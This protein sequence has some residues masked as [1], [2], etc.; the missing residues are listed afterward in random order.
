[1]KL[2]KAYQKLE[3]QQVQSPEALQHNYKHLQEKLKETEEQLEQA[4]ET[5][6]EKK[7]AIKL[8]Q[9]SD[10]NQEVR[11]GLLNEIVAVAKIVKYVDCTYDLC[12]KFKQP[13]VE[14]LVQL[15]SLSFL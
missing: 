7:K 8:F 2:K 4:K 3:A 15:M 6:K 10:K 9:T 11:L 13:I 14:R 1:M 5:A 12:E